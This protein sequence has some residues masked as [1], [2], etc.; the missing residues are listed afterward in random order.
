M[1]NMNGWEASRLLRTLRPTLPIFAS[2]GHDIS[3]DSAV[4]HGVDVAGILT[5]P[6][7]LDELRAVLEQA[8]ALRSAASAA[9]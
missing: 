5:K 4:S 3:A 1:P 7:G 2:S 6:Y 8:E 9:P